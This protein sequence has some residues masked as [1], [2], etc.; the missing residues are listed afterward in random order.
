MNFTPARLTKFK[1]KYKEMT[2]FENKYW[3]NN[4]EFVA[5][6]DEAGRGP[7]AGPVVA[8]CCILNPDD[9]ILGIN[10]SKKVSE[11]MREYL[12]DEIKA[13]AIS[14]QIEIV[15]HNIIDDI[16]I[17]NATKIAMTK[18]I[19]NLSHKPDIVLIDAVKLEDLSVKSDSIIKGDLKSIS[20]AAASILAKVTR[21]EIM[22]EYEK[23]YPGYGFSRNKGYGTKLHYEG[24]QKH[25]ITPIHRKTF[26]KGLI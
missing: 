14:Y 23:K 10:D 20:I 2:F 1:E 7:L 22:K 3:S 8:A 4:I 17:L 19:E 9:P 12:F 18:S 26:L 24:I 21:D 25:G 6:V 11:K 13:R 16:N 5:G 15:E